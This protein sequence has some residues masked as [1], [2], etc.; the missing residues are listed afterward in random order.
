MEDQVPD[1][2]AY[3]REYRDLSAEVAY[4]LLQ[5]EEIPQ[6]KLDR[7]N[8]LAEMRVACSAPDFEYLVS[9]A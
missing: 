4:A 1:F 2:E 9:A 7:L 3:E 8:E 6:S 5:G